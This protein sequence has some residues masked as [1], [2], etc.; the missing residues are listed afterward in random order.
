METLRRGHYDE[1]ARSS[2]D[3]V[4]GLFILH[5]NATY[6]MN[7]HEYPVLAIGVLDRSR[8]F[9]LVALFVISENNAGCR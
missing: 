6:K 7:Y 2:D 4:A 3:A 1:D 8:G 9:H 5:V